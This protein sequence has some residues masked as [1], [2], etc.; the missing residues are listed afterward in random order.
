M[1]QPR[2]RGQYAAAVDRREIDVPFAH[3]ADRRNGYWGALQKTSA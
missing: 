1:P 2:H 3:V